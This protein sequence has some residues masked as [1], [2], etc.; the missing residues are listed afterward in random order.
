[1][2]RAASHSAKYKYKM[3]LH[4]ELIMEKKD[5]LDLFNAILNVKN[6]MFPSSAE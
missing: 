2:L 1:M 6:S 4:C 3:T 5:E